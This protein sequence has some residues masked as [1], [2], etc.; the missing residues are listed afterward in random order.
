MQR[1]YVIDPVTQFPI[2]RISVGGEIKEEKTQN[3]VVELFFNGR[4]G[5][6][7]PKRGEIK[8]L[9]S[10]LFILWGN[11]SKT[12]ATFSWKK[13]NAIQTDFEV[14]L[15]DL[16]PRLGASDVRRYAEKHWSERK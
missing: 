8:L 2:K 1:R 12:E 15:T 4:S 5:A 7:R 13:P 9:M 3:R 11:Y 6:G 14:F 16:L 10:R